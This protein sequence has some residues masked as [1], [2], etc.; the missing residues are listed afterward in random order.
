MKTMAMVGM[1]ALF[2]VGATGQKVLVMPWDD[3]PANI[4]APNSEK[5]VYW[6][7]ATGVQVYTCQAG[8]GGKYSWVLKEPRANLLD[9]DGKQVG[10][11]FAGPTWKLNDGSEV[12][13]KAVAKY[14]APKAGAIPWLLIKATGNKGHGAL[15]HVTSIQRT[16]TEGGVVGAAS[17]CD[18]KKRWTES[19][20]AYSA[21]YYFYASAK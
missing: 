3:V 19:E 1:L 21:D 15:E 20:S 17:V 7:S 4:K 10:L 18:E 9:E 6:A 5:M 11:H 13:G 8:T 16:H 12:T 14:D 2:S